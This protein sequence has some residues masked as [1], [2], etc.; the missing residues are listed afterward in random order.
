M[1]WSRAAATSSSF[2]PS[3]QAERG[4]LQGVVPLGDPLP[5]LGVAPAL[6]QFDQP[7]DPAHR[8]LGRG[9]T[10]PVSR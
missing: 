8:D 1:S 3:A 5:V 9:A 2:A 4:A 6:Q 10:G 7:G